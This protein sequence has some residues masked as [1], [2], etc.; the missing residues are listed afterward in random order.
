MRKERIIFAIAAIA[1][2]VAG[3]AVAFG[4]LFYEATK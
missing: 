2:L 4:V 3:T 1:L